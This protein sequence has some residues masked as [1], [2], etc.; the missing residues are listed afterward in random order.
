M[1]K[2]EKYTNLDFSVLSLG[3]CVLSAL[4][5]N[6]NMKYDELFEYVISRKGEKSKKNFLSSLNLLFLLGKVEYS[7]DIDVIKVT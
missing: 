5:S 2:P 4:V 1:L 3:A 6:G 7:Q